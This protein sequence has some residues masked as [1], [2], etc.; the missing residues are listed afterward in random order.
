MD[1]VSSDCAVTSHRQGMEVSVVSNIMRS[2]KSTDRG[3]CGRRR[4]QAHSAVDRLRPAVYVR[5]QLILQ[6]ISTVT[7]ICWE[8]LYSA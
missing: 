4:S 2:T 1:L 8:Y 7:H 5:G 6:H 3:R